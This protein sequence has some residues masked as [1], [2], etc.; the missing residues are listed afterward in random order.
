MVFDRR[1]RR[2]K[3]APLTT[4]KL[5]KKEASVKSTA[6]PVE[7]A[8]VGFRVG[9]RDYGSSLRNP[10]YR[11]SEFTTRHGR[12][13]PG[14][15]RGEAASTLQE[16]TENAPPFVLRSG[17]LTAWMAGT[18]PAMTSHC[19][20]SLVYYGSASAGERS[21]RGEAEENRFASR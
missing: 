4:A 7:L 14:H 21:P 17:G 9:L 6:L 8:P 13:C 1:R 11:R 10:L 16:E 18:S 20:R 19:L 5:R 2:A 3:S 12:A 15:P